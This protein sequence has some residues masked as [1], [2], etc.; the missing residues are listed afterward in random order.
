[1]WR[2]DGAW[3]LSYFGANVLHPRTTLPAMRY[4]IPITLRNYFNLDAPGTS[5][6]DNCIVPPADKPSGVGGSYAEIK[7]MVNYVKGLAT[8][9]D[10]CL[11]NVEGTGMVGVPGTANAVFQTVRDAGCNVVMIS[12]ASSEHSICF[13]VRSHEAE[14]AIVAL[15][16]RFEKAIAAGRIKV[17]LY[18]LIQC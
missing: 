12:Q 9:D 17:G 8:I 3:E 7:D 11:I 18:K 5:I 13:A 1:L 6:S 4:S 15:N 2:Y 10:V 16:K 14:S